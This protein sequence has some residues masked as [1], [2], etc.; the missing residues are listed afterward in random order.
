VA[1]SAYLKAAMDHMARLIDDALVH[2]GA[3]PRRS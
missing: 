1:P 3:A 2:Q